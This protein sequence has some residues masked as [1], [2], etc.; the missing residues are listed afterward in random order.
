ML[1]WNIIFNAFLKSPVAL[2]HRCTLCN[3]IGEVQTRITKM[4][5]N[6]RQLFHAKSKIN[7]RL[8]TPINYELI[9]TKL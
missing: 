8:F 3:E 9:I 7:L 6:G 2:P 4:I 1:V 5:S